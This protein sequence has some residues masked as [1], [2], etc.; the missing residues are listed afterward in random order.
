MRLNEDDLREV[1]RLDSMNQP[2]LKALWPGYFYDRKMAIESKLKTDFDSMFGQPNVIDFA[3]L[4]YTAGDAQ[5]IKLLKNF[6]GQVEIIQGRQDP[7]GESTVYEI[8]N[9]LP[10]S[11]VTFIERCGHFPWLEREEPEQQFFTILNNALY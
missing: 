5:R 3:Y 7:I 4:N 6:T 1:T 10:Q 11:N 2:T 9:I 8:A